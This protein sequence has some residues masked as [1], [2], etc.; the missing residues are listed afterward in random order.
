MGKEIWDHECLVYSQVTPGRYKIR[1]EYVLSTEELFG[2]RE[3]KD[4]NYT[5]KEFIIK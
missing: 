5:E 1:F 4:I 2:G 3:G